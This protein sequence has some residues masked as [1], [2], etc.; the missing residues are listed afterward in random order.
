[1]SE[2]LEG[3]SSPP[4]RRRERGPGYFEVLRECPGFR[5]LFLAR[6][7]SL[8]GD[9]FSVI[10]IIAMFRQ[11][12]GSS[13]GAISG[14][15]I[16][17]LLP[18]FLA[19]P[20][21][22]VVAD[23]VNRKRIMVASD[24]VRAVFVLMVLA[25]PLTPRP[26]AVTYV[27]ITV[28]VVA[29]AF[30]EPARTAAL[31]QLVPARYL[32]AANALGAVVWSL[33]FAVGSAIGGVVTDAFGWQVA[34]T[35]D[36]ATYVV[37][38]ALVL[39]ITL[40]RRPVRGTVAA[41]WMTLTGVRDFREGV[42]FIARRLD[43]ASVLS[44]KVGWGLAGAVTLF[45]TLFGERV[46]APLGRPDLG[47]GLLYLSRAVG[48]ALGPV[49]ARRIAPEESPRAMRL[50]LAVAL[51]WGCVWY[52]GFSVS[53]HWATAALTVVLAHFGGS[54]VWV[55]SSVLLQRMVPD[56]L[57][58]RVISTDLGL[59]TLTISASLWFYGW[60]AEAGADLGV[61]VQATALS[62]LVPAALWWWAAGRWPVGV[63]A[64]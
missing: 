20:V 1:M 16:L 48:T 55:Y 6:A 18:I 28:Q 29:S 7:I 59:A 2:Q 46:Y 45:L 44:L 35:I 27:L 54:I 21:A 63:P 41:D 3:A 32:A 19:G 47:V 11:V 24:V 17:K 57:L 43:V 40:P 39:R 64:E 30:F 22:G 34:L 42:R 61:L 60:L 33:M 5:L 58:G 15:F 9:W 52:L 50:L 56:Q 26:T 62:L 23:R 8:F 38:A 25:A 12:T 10:A 53:H 14:M 4:G 36:A 37:S 31:P 13:P 49:L 51:V